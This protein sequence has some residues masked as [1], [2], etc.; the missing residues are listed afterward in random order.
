GHATVV[1]QGSA[2]DVFLKDHSVSVV[3][4]DPPYDSMV[5][6]TDSSDLFFAWTKRALYST[7]PELAITAD[8]RGLQDK[9]DE[10][11]VKEHG[12][13]PGEH[14]NREHYDR[15]MAKA[16]S[17]M[18]RVVRDSGTV[19]IVFGHGEPEVWQRLLASI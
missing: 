7:R 15:R 9:S 1:T 11:I 6:Y 4:T 19:T 14:R 17:E 3:V 5:Y 13:S 8:P 18:R 10:I 16:F 12:K 2:A